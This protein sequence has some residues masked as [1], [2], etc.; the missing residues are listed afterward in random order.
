MKIAELPAV[1]DRIVVHGMNHFTCVVHSTE[2]KEDV[3]DWKINLDWGA[4][5][6]SRVWLRDEDVVWY[7]VSTN[8]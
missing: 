4:H 1:G 5:G 2:W 6:R 7:R 3:V 8:N